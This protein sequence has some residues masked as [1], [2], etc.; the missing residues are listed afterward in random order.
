MEDG[1]IEARS[2]TFAGYI[3]TVFK[4]LEDSDAME[5]GT[6]QYNIYAGIRFKIQ[7]DL[8]LQVDN[9]TELVLPITDSYIGARVVICE[10]RKA[11]SRN[12][13]LV[14]I[15]T[16]DESSIGGIRPE[17]AQSTDHFAESKIIKFVN[18]VIEL[19]GTPGYSSDG[20]SKCKWMVLSYAAS[21]IYGIS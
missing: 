3:R 18:G 5:F 1:S 20:E 10:N 4:T 9:Y 17:D 12:F 14:T 21:S 16:E 2:G 11:Y 8:N 13:E 19:I 15:Y 6:A 7:N